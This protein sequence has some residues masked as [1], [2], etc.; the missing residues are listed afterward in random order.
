M[1]FCLAF[2]IKRPLTASWYAD[3]SKAFCLVPDMAQFLLVKV[4][5]RMFIAKYSEPQAES[6]DA[7]GEMV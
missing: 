3:Q 2:P 1:C 6:S 7:K 4:Q 5:P